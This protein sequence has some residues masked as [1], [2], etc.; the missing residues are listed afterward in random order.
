MNENDDIRITFPS[1]LGIEFSFIFGSNNF[2]TSTVN[3]QVI[4]CPHR[5]SPSKTNLPGI[6]YFFTIT[7]IRAPVSTKVTDKIKVEVIRNGL[8]KMEGFTTIQA[9]PKVLTVTLDVSIHTVWASTQYK[10]TIQIADSLSSTGMVKIYFPT[11]INPTLLT[12]CAQLS[13][14]GLVSVPVCSY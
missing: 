5:R 10:F 14:T 12:S 9:L 1:S 7:N 4:T 3:G 11:E 2:G 8:T 13:G 6:P